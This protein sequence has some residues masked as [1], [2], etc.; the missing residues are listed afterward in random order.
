MLVA[1]GEGINKLSSYGKALHFE[2]KGMLSEELV[3]VEAT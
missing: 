3:T 1:E 2:G